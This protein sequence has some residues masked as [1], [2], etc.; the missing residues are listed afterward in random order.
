MM[1]ER[2]RLAALQEQRVAALA[3]RVLEVADVH[4]ERERLAIHLRDHRDELRLFVAVVG[5]V[6]ER[7]EGELRAARSASATQ[8]REARCQRHE[9]PPATATRHHS[10]SF[11]RS[12]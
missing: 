8:Q 12:R 2:E 10:S 9:T 4:R 7:G 5:H 6:A 1:R 3:A 11:W